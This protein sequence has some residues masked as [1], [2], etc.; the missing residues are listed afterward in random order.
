MK[1]HYAPGTIAVATGLL[2]QETGLDHTPVAVD[3][4]NAA[5]TGPDYLA[6][7]PKGRVPALE[8]GQGV[9]TETGAILE[10]IAAQAP[11]MGLVPA[12]P[13][14]AGQVRAICYYLAS[15]MHVNHAHGRRGIRWADNESSLQDMR[16]KVP[17]TMAQSAAFLEETCALSPF[18]MG[19]AMTI[20]DPWLFAVTCWL[21]TDD[22][23]IDR[24]PKL[25]AH[26]AMMAARPSAAAIRDYGLLTKDFA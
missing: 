9:L 13:W 3:F 19:E 17:Q 11:G 24:F 16:A 1:F 7:N 2:L 26:R 21:E 20:A 10:Y 18:V 12:D 8:T 25:K 23:D 14:Q 5:Q 15:T 6:V 4:A 22:V